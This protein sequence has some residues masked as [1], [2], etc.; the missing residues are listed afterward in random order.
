VAQ[1]F[2]SP[3]LATEREQVVAQVTDLT[4]EL[5]AIVALSMTETPDDEH[6]AE[7]STIGF[8]R[9][10]VSALLAHAK[11]RLADLDAALQRL[12]SGAYGV[13]GRCGQPIGSERLEALP[14]TVTCIRCAGFGRPSGG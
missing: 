3:E 7:G 13:C 8:E 12:Q 10:R 11:Q 1:P 4:A 14:T 2:G 6:D 9:A 5:D